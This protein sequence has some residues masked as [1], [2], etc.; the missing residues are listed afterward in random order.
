MQAE[1]QKIVKHIQSECE[2]EDSCDGDETE[3][4]EW[5]LK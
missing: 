2:N 5:P 4:Y 3:E 1:I